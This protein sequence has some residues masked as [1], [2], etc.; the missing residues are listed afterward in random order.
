MGGIYVAYNVG[1]LLAG[2]RSALAPHRSITADCFCGS[3]ALLESSHTALGRRVL[4]TARRD[5][6]DPEDGGGTATDK[7]LVGRVMSTC[8]CLHRNK[9]SGLNGNPCSS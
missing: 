1:R 5:L 9:S 4:L 8:W 7:Q 2:E 3:P 6:P